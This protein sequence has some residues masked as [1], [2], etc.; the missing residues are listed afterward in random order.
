MF[1][2]AAV[3]NTSIGILVFVVLQF[4]GGQAI[5]LFFNSSESQV[6]RIAVDGLHIY[7]FVFLIN[8][9][10][11]LIT[12]YFTALGNAK[13]SIIIAALRGPVFVLVGVTVLAKFLGI[14]GVWAAIPL[15]ELLTLGVALILL[16]LT[17]R[18]TP[19]FIH[20]DIRRK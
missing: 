6:F 9:L 20:G 13:N 2:F 12:T 7:T 10:N 11:V 14:N 5:R 15:A 19:G 17:R 8:G 18:K 3:V 16:I 1:R 4:F